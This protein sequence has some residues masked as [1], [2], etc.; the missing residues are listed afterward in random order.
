MNNYSEKWSNTGSKNI[1]VVLGAAVWSGN[2]P[3]P[4]LASRIDKAAK[5]YK[6][7]IADKI[8]LTG[9]NAPGEMTEAEVAFNYILNKNVDTTDILIEKQTT[10]T[11]EQIRF[12]KDNLAHRNLF[13]NIFIVSDQ[14]HLARVSEISRFYNLD[15]I[16]AASELELSFDSK[17]YSRIRECIALS[18]FWCFA[19]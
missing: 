19:I 13:D 14:Y 18:I 3:S 10:S 6:K 17:M 7:D 16:A 9:S 2:Q 1:A 11:T 15:V 5:L 4:T 8:L 12:I